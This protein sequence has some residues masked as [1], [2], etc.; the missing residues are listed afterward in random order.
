M[1]LSFLEDYISELM[2]LTLDDPKHMSKT[3]EVWGTLWEILVWEEKL[4]PDLII[5]GDKMAIDRSSKTTSIETETKEGKAM[6]KIGWLGLT[7]I[8]GVV[9]FLY[10]FFIAP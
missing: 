5:D 9:C 2:I 3:E 7:V 1:H 10:G 6:K 8:V 4:M